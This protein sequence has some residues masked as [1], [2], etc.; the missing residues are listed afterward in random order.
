L[1]EGMS[2]ARG[3]VRGA[4]GWGWPMSTD[5]DRSFHD[6]I[7]R[8]RGG[9]QDAALTLVRRY[10]PAVRRAVRVRLVDNRLRRGLDSMDICQSVLASFFVRA[11][12]GQYDLDRPE[13]LLK[14][15][16]TMARNKLADAARGQATGRRGGGRV[17]AG[18]LEGCDA[19]PEPGPSPSRAASAKELLDLALGRLA[20][21][22]RWL[23][24]QRAAGRAWADLAAEV[25]CQPDALRQRLNRAVDRV[26]RELDLDEVGHG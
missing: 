5:D 26:C 15:L 24:E 12:A 18:G 6:L 1:Y 21:Q 19:L 7:R 9:D 23:A 11:A 14:L 10:E 17:A 13:D 4:G 20:G 16:T 2:N 8:V 25:G 22:E 3:P